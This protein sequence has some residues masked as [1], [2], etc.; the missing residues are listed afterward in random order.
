LK[1]RADW[2]IILK[3]IFTKHEDVNWVKLVEDTL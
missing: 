2:K 1:I 3:C